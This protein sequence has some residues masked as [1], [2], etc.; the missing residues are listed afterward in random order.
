MRS[1]FPLPSLSLIH[2]YG[3][4]FPARH[5]GR[6]FEEDADALHGAGIDHYDAAAVEVFVERER[7]LA[8][9]GRMDDRGFA[10]ELAAN[11]MCIRDS[12]IG[13]ASCRE[14]V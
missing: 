11:E 13:R 7:A 12:K 14:R 3:A 9:D 10:A 6:G 2:I 1:R 8:V 5:A 4:E